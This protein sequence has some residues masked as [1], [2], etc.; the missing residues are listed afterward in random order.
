MDLGTTPLE[1]RL[2]LEPNPRKAR[3]SVCGLTVCR[4]H[5]QEDSDSPPQKGKAAKGAGKAGGKGKTWQAKQEL[6]ATQ[7]DPTPRNHI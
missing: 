6:G 2:L 1:I 7:R 5:D 3:F 4:L